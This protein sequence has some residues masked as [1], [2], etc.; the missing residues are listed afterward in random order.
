MSYIF[1]EM[2]AMSILLKQKQRWENNK[3]VYPELIEKVIY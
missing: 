2:L 3:N 1:H